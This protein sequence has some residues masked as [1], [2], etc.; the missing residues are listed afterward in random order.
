VTSNQDTS[1]PAQPGFPAWA[2]ADELARLAKERLPED[3]YDYVASGAGDDLTLA[4]NVSAFSRLALVPSVLRD[5]S[6][7][8]TGCEIAGTRLD[9]PLLVAPVGMQ[10]L[11]DEGG[12]SATASGAAEAGVGFILST[13]SSVPMEDVAKAAGP[14]RWFQL[15]FV[16]PDRGVI[17]DLV[18]RASAS[19]FTALC[20]TVDNPVHGFR[21]ATLRRLGS[22]RRRDSVF[23]NLE[24]YAEVLGADAAPAVADLKPAAHFPATW[25]DIEWL[26]GSTDLPILLKGVLDPADASRA[27][28]M[29]LDGVVVSNHGGRQLDHGV[30]T[31]EALPD[32]V[33]AV[34]GASA[35]LLDGGIRRPSDAVIALALGA[36][37][38]CLGRLVMWALALGGREGVAGLLRQ[39]RLELT[40]TMQLVG[41]AGVSDLRRSMVYDRLLRTRMG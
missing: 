6:G 12:E 4:G 8:S 21:R 20:V 23:A 36:N 38:V 32:I 2:G 37:G 29:G 24:P 35:V 3:V 22:T 30:A 15:Y 39:F 28:A 16:T 34:G 40:R 26:R 1:A 7:I 10:G 19:G 33:D 25:A 9:C 17:A 14:A 18:S 11:L 27:A 31:V 41:A 5:V 13:G